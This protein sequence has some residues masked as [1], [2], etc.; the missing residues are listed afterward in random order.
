M[1]ANRRKRRDPYFIVILIILAL[2]ISLLLLYFLD[3]EGREP[4]ADKPSRETGSI[5]INSREA[6]RE[7]ESL[8]KKKDFAWPVNVMKQDLQLTQHRQF[9]L[10]YSEA[11]EQAVWVAY[12]LSNR[13]AE[14]LHDR[15]NNFR[16]DP[17]I[18]TGSANPRDYT[19][20]GYDR[21]HLAPAADFDYSKKALGE[22]FYMS[23]ISPQT[24]VFNRGGW[25][26][27]EEQVR[28]WAMQED[29][30][31]VITGPVLTAGLKKI[32]TNR[33]SV[34]NYFYK[35][36]LDVRQPEIK[37]I[38]FLMPNMK[39]SRELRYWVVTADSVEQL[40]G[41]DFFPQLPDVLE[42]SLERVQQADY[43]FQNAEFK[44]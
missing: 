29:S 42:D 15:R 4:A 21:G 11:H 33:V 14:N 44:N 40:S 34:P 18:N 8:R 3:R 7:L 32:G 27:L 39:I 5:N 9:S 28:D 25:K 26:E 43:W 1:A 20:T 19:N 12:L 17:A 31:W 41:L 35:I 6:I 37:M 22:S 16:A 13:H 24:P 10:G 23:N 2:L 36:I 30:L 38:S